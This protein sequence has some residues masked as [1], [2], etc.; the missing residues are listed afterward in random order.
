MPAKG[1]STPAAFAE[2][3]RQ[4]IKTKVE[5]D[6]LVAAIEANDL[7]AVAKYIANDLEKAAGSE[8]TEPIKKMLIEQGALGSVMTGS[9]AAV[10]GIFD[11]EEKARK[12]FQ[13]FKGKV[14]SVF[15]A[16]PVDFGATVTRDRGRKY[17]RR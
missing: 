1:V 8:D 3:D 10:F 6:K 15:L 7:P 5:T 14:R 13:F 4:G 12:A 16:K 11:D 17:S 2:Y 9:G